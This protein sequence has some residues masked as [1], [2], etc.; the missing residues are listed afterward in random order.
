MQCLYKRVMRFD[1]IV[2]DFSPR[3][4]R[5]PADG[6]FHEIGPMVYKSLTEQSAMTQ[7]NEQ[8]SISSIPI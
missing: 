8:S 7:L 6:Q 4:P 2:H 3:D 1:P 5:I